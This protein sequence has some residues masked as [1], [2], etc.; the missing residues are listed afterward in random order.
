MGGILYSWQFPHFHAL[1]WNLRHDYTKAGYR[2]AAATNPRVCTQ[3]SLNHTIGLLLMCSCLAPA[4]DL[5]TLPF[6]IIT[7]PVNISFI[8]LARKFKK[9]QDASSSRQLFKYSLYYLPVIIILLFCYKK[10]VSER[11]DYLSELLKTDLTWF[12]FPAIFNL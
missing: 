6:A 8:Y 10:P 4:L 1:S 9:N 2:M 3:S 11:F 12:D 5:T 7:L